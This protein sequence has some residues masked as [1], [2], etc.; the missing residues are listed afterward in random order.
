MNLIQLNVESSTEITK[1][2][3]IRKYFFYNVFHH[4]NVG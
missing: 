2:T 1:T 3:G 4:N